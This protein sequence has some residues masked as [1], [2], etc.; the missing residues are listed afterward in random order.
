VS[1]VMVSVSVSVK[2]QGTQSEPRRTARP[3]GLAGLT[4]AISLAG[5]EEARFDARQTPQMKGPRHRRVS[6]SPTWARTR[7]LRINSPGFYIFMSSQEV[8]L[9]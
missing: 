8:P 6:G 2:L 3:V 5:A 7:D 4:C 9:P 1:L